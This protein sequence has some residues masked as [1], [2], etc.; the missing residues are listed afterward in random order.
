MTSAWSFKLKHGFKK[1]HSGTSLVV[2][3]LRLRAPNAGGL[4][5]IPGQGT[6]SHMPQLKI[7]RATT[8]TQHSQKNKKKKKK[9]K[10]PLKVPERPTDFNVQ[11]YDKFTDMISEPA[12]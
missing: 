10:N 3:W 7:L 12:L 5:S 1:T 2:Q 11:E 4:G 8:K 9:K 6:R